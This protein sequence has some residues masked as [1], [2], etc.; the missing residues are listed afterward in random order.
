MT[1]VVILLGSV[2]LGTALGI[3][4]VVFVGLSYSEDHVLPF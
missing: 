1:I 3:A 4:G 2:I